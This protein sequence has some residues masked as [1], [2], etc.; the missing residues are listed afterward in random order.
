MWRNVVADKLLQGVGTK[1]LHNYLYMRQAIVEEW[2]DLWPIFEVCTKET[3]YGGG[4][5]IRVPLWRHAAAE[6]HLRVTL[7]EISEAARERRRREPG[8]S[9]K[10]EGG[11]VGVG[12]DSNR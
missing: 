10:G 7:G 9:G 2:V 6:K 3:D 4:C 8:R 1:P 12:K 5:N 11:V